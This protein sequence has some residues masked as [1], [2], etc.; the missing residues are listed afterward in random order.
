MSVPS[1]SRDFTQAVFDYLAGC[2][3]VPE[4]VLECAGLAPAQLLPAAAG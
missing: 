4:A 2:G 1:V 3:F